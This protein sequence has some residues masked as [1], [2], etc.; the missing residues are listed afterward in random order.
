MKLDNFNNY[1]KYLNYRISIPYFKF[2][3]KTTKLRVMNFNLN[4]KFVFK[5]YGHI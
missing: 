4:Y 5:M 3:L 1:V 2:K